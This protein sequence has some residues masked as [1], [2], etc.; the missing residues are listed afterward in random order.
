[1]NLA[2]PCHA[3]PQRTAPLPTKRDRSIPL[4]TS[5]AF[6]P[7]PNQT[8]PEREQP[9]PVVPHP[10]LPLLNLPRHN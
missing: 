5:P 3:H 8:R 6:R 7:E 4:L 2:L 1:M 9:D 10:N